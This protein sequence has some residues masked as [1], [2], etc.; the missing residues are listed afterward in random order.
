MDKWQ[1]K[2]SFHET[3]ERKGIRT[4]QYRMTF[5]V[6]GKANELYDHADDPWEMTNQWDNPA[7]N[8]VRRELSEELLRYIAR[9]ERQTAA[10]S[11]RPANRAEMPAGP[12]YDLWWNN[13]S[14]EEVK[15][16]YR[17]P[18]VPRQ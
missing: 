3:E 11:N 16:K 8:S 15:R 18:A 13:M 4:A 17:L 1:R 12:T 2:A 6:A 9:T 7:Y 10:T 5:D 14:W